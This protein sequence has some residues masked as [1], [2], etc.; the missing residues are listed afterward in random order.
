MIQLAPFSFYVISS[1]Y[2]SVTEKNIHIGNIVWQVT[3]MFVTLEKLAQTEPKYAEVFLLE[4]YA[5]FQNS[6]YDLA[7]VVQTLA[8][9]YHQASEAYEQACQR[10]LSMIIYFQFERLFMFAKKIEDLMFTIPPEEIPFQLGLSKMDLRKT[11]KSSLSGVD[12]S[13]AAMYK[14]LQKNLTSEE[15]LPSLWDKCKKEFLEKYDSFAQLCA[16]IYPSETIPS[17]NE[18]RELLASM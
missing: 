18:M 13:I 3:I 10:H 17:V 11:L 8:K 7:N 9:F 15:L 1:E 6:L 4:N 2:V 5:A 16:K 12:K 14:K